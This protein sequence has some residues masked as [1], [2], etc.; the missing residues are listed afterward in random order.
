MKNILLLVHDDAGQ[1][2]RLQAAL[3]VARALGGHLK[4]LDVTPVTVIAGDGYGSDGSVMMLEYES[5]Q[6]SANRQR[7]QQRLAVE[8]VPW[9][10]QDMT[11]VIGDCIEACA[12]LADLVVLNRQLDD[13][14]IPDMRHIVTRLVAKAGLPVLAV[15]ADAKGF[16]AAGSAL[17]AWDG[18][19]EAAAA[20]AAAVPLLKLAGSVTIL[21]VDDGSI[22]APAEEAATYLSRHDI[23]ATIVRA[24]REGDVASN[25]MLA[26]AKS[27]NFDY[28]VMGGFGHRGFVEAIFGGVT[29]RMLTKSPIPVL[30]AH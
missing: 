21:E 7:L 23:K 10:W 12:T 24:D 19:A 20:L 22:K 17:V 29:R 27:G 3:D 30:L 8:D 26:A 11:G 2:A 16:D 14:P 1:E 15:P 25:V 9:D 6:E 5:Q 18:S 28:L 13:Y 4:C